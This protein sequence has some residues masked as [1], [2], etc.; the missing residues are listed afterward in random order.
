MFLRW[1]IIRAYQCVREHAHPPPQ[2]SLGLLFAIL[3]D[4]SD[5]NYDSVVPAFVTCGCGRHE[6]N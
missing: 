3:F 1:N 2:L 5:S 4:D 6:L